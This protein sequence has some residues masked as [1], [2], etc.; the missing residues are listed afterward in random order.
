MV[1]RYDMTPAE[2]EETR[3]AYVSGGETPGLA[4]GVGSVS[5]VVSSNAG[6]AAVGGAVGTLLMTG[7]LGTAVLI[8][9]FDVASFA[10]LAELVGLPA[11]PL[12]GAVLFLV[13][14]TVTWPLIFLAFSEF[15]PGRLLFETGLVFATLISTGFAVAF[16]TGQ[17]GFAL[18]GY[19][20]FVL[21][22]HWSYGLGLAVTFQFLRARRGDGGSEGS[23]SRGAVGGGD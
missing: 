3:P 10:E 22:A 2:P 18:L 20:G 12:V 11:N 4:S 21:V 23:G 17:S 8:G 7:G 14:G 15:L 9:V 16:Y 13:G 1:E 5:R 19:L 6:M